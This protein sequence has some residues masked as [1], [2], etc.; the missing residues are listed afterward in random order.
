MLCGASTLSLVSCGLGGFGS[1]DSAS[2]PSIASAARSIP[3]GPAADYPMVLGEPFTID[4]ITYTP[5]DTYNYDEVGYATLDDDMADGITVA[6]RTLPLPSYVEITSLESGRTILARVERR[7]PMTNMRLLG[8]SR[9]A[10]G[11][12]G[13]G[14][15]APVRVRRVNPPED[16]RAELRADRSVAPRME[17]PQGLLDVLKRQLPEVGSVSL[18]KAATGARPGELGD[19]PRSNIE[20]IDPTTEIE[21]TPTATRP[22]SSPVPAPSPAS[23][24]A[25][26]DVPPPAPA[27]TPAV[28][29]DFAVQ[30]GAYSSRASAQKVADAVGGY[31]EPAG[32]LF[33]VR[34]GPFVNRGEAATALAKVRGAGYRDA[35]IVTTR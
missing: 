26:E 10:A 27:A 11:Q 3:T 1:V 7:G 18:A 16:Q 19:S 22:K 6:H 25:T 15:G 8:L 14:E 9:A 4:G 35:Q 34:V 13:V 30:A 5:A 24:A 17:T 29:G 28:R 31:L 2:D 23:P 21:P 33:R 12:L 32:S 20:T